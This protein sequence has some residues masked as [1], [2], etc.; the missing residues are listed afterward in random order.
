[1]GHCPFPCLQGTALSLR[2]ILRSAI[3][4][5][6]ISEQ[7]FA[8]F[9]ATIKTV[10][11]DFAISLNDVLSHR[12]A[13]D[14]FFSRFGHLRP[15]TYYI[16]TARYSAR[17]NSFEGDKPMPAHNPELFVLTPNEEKFLDTRVSEAGFENISGTGL[18][19]YYRRSRVAREHGKF[20]ISRNLADSI[21]HFADWGIDVGLT[22][23]DLSHLSQR[24]FGMTCIGSTERN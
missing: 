15:G 2:R 4:P 18:L 16:L 3:S 22:R 1:M 14:V 23:E 13:P 7:R 24:N 20:V 5:G 19:E 11:T 12:L 10:A 21:D 6:A 17:P 8:A 9:K